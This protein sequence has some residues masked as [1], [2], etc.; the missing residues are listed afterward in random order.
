ML[1]PKEQK[2]DR[3]SRCEVH[4]DI[5]CI[6]GGHI[7]VKIIA[8]FFAMLYPY[9]KGKNLTISWFNVHTRLPFPATLI[10]NKIGGCWLN[11]TTI[12]STKLYILG[13]QQL[14]FKSTSAEFKLGRL[15]EIENCQYDCEKTFLANVQTL[16]EKSSK[17][18][19]INVPI[20][21]YNYVVL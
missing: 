16:A 21:N 9:P 6:F 18:V 8:S 1:K 4:L 20:S 3:I 17:K 19:W 2:E 11:S 5:R 7:A 14:F 10:E 13:R 12:R 15:K